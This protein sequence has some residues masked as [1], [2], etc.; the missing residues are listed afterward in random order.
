V[1][2]NLLEKKLSETSF[3]SASYSDLLEKFIIDKII[4][5]IMIITGIEIFNNHGFCPMNVLNKHRM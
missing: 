4:D 2:H 3:T 5:E 1:N